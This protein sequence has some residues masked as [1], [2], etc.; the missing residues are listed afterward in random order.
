R[1]VYVRP[2][3]TGEGR[4]KISTAGGEQPRWRGDGREMFYTAEGKI[5]A[6]TVTAVPG[7]KP[8]FDPGVPVPLFDS[9]MVPP[10]TNVDDVFRYDVTADG[11]RFLV[12]TNNPTAAAAPLTVVVNWNAGLQK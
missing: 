6:V 4:W 9:H 8:S 7:P 2:F 1:E 12:V 3:P 10:G 5:T 11:K